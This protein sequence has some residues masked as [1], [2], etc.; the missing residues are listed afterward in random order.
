MCRCASEMVDSQKTGSK[1]NAVI[2]KRKEIKIVTYNIQ[3]Y[4][5]NVNDNI[6]C[7]VDYQK[8]IACVA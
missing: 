8:E 2:L 6:F 4:S 7:C 1:L 3:V 5:D